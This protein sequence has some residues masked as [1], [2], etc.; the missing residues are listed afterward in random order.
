MSFAPLIQIERK[1]RFDADGSPRRVTKKPSALG[2]ENCTL[3]DVPGVNKIFGKVEG[4][5]IFIWG[6]SPGAQENKALQEFV[7][8]SGDFLWT[9]LKRIGIKRSM[10]DIQNAVRCYPADFDTDRYPPLGSRNP[11]KEEIK[12]CSVYTKKAIADSKA[13]LHL[14]FGEIAQKQVLGSEYSKKKRIFWSDKLNGHVVCLY[15][16][17]YFLRMGYRAGSTLKP[18]AQLTSFRADLD[19]AATLL[20]S[21]GR[22]GYLEEQEYIGVVDPTTADLAYADI[23][24]KAKKVR[25]AVDIEDGV[26]DDGRMDILCISFCGEAGK[27]WVFCLEHTEGIS[28][29]KDIRAY[30]WKIVKKLLSDKTV[31][32]V[33]H[34]GSYDARAITKKMGVKLE[35]YDYDTE[36]GEYFFDANAKAYGLASITSRRM[37]EFAGYKEI[38]APEAFTEA[39]RAKIPKKS[40]VSLSKRYEAARKQNALNMAQVPWKKM[41]LYNG[42]DCDVTKRIEI[43]TKKFVNMPL[44]HVYMDAGFLMA[45]MEKRGPWFDYSQHEKLSRLYPKRVKKWENKLKEISGK[46]DFNP[47]STK[48]VMWLLYDFLNL[49]PP[50]DNDSSPNTQADTLQL[51]VDQHEAVQ[52]LLNF[53]RDAKLLSTYLEGFLISANAHEG[54]LATKWWL[55]GTGTGRLSSGAG[56]EQEAKA[57]GLVNLQ[58]IVSDHQLQNMAVSDPNW[59]E[60][61]DY[62]KQNG[63]FTEETAKQFEDMN[64]FLGFDQGQFEI[65]VVAQRSGDKNLIDVFKRGEDI[66]A[67]V[68][69]QLMKLPIE[70]LKKEG[71]ER[72]AVKGMHF[73]IIYGLMAAG[74][75]GHLL[76]EY[77]RRNMKLPK[78]MTLQ[79]VQNLLDNY[80]KTYPKVR[81]MID[82]DH[83]QAEQYGFV[84]TMFGFRRKLNVEEQKQL[85]DEWKGAY[86]KNQAANTPIQ[87]TAHQLLLIGLINI[88]RDKEKYKLLRRAAMEIHDAMY[89]YVKLKDMWAAVKLGVDMLEKESLKIVREE[90]GIDWKVPLMVEPKAGFRFGVQVYKLGGK[91]P[92][93]TSAF[94]NEW[95]RTNQ[96]IEKE[97]REEIKK[98]S[99]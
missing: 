24:A 98:L 41:V 9:E 40:V 74:L 86:W 89:F 11:T 90:F 2:C 49:T 85:G 48:Q 43:T 32:K 68:G 91:G 50:V 13:K 30:N 66:H 37:P 6:M 7:G 62:W 17:S 10:C 93:T 4:K 75:Y 69:S 5:D 22:Y 25:I 67:S 60:I 71:P 29:A 1:F 8:P 19:Y 34:H 87:G 27:S 53:R 76:T 42:A 51:M 80:F 96:G 56:R 23:K 65:R 58:N 36:Y 33:F 16:P 94:L 55:T 3:N 14:V 21:K 54:R 15:H 52:V 20:E 83:K 18:N 73:G 81:Q 35:G 88:I 44:M 38:V 26:L 59:K 95:C 57:Q 79:W 99:Y 92:R 82:G 63:D 28:L 31:R 12:C 64:V 77:K 78:Y 39:F 97:L 84:E 70:T 61:Y 46:E 72:V 47:R 45:E